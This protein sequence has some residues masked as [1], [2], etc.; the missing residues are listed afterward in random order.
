[1][2][3]LGIAEVMGYTK[4]IG[5]PVITDLCTILLPMLAFALFRVFTAS[6][7]TEYAAPRATTPG[8]EEGSL[9][10]NGHRG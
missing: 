9:M 8:D 1:V 6:R 2:A 10:T 4:I 3:F 7:E 5:T